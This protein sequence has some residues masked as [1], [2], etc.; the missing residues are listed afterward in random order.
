V[1][2]GLP[3]NAH[4]NVITTDP[5]RVEIPQTESSPNV[6]TPSPVGSFNEIASDEE[7][8]FVCDIGY[9]RENGS[10]IPSRAACETE[11]ITIGNYTIASCNVG[12][13][14]AGTGKLNGQD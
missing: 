3:A 9:K 7:C 12:A 8:R 6:W 2:R 13:T 10:C 11:T 14:V 1:C 5:S 4:W